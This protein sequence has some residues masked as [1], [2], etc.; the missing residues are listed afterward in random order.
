MKENKSNIVIITLFIT[1]LILT[2]FL[3]IK[4]NIN[5]FKEGIDSLIR[6]EN[7]NTLTISEKTKE[8]N[9]TIDTIFSNKIAGKY[10][11]IDI[12]GLFQNTMNKK[13]IEDV[14]DNKRV[15]KLSNNSLAFIYPD[16]D[17]SNWSDK[18]T[19]VSD[20]AKENNIYMLYV[21]APWRIGKNVT[22]PFYIKDNVAKVDKKF[23]TKLKE[24]KVNVLRLKDKLKG[25]EKDWFFGTDH[26]WNIETAFESYKIIMK[27]IDKNVNLGLKEEYLNNYKT[28]VYKNVFLG[29]Y[30]KRVGKYYGKPD[31]FAYILPN[32][33]TKFDVINNIKWDSEQSHLVGSFDKVFTYPEYVEKKELDRESSTYYTYA[34]G[35]KAEVKITNLKAYNDKKV[36]ILKDSF[37]EPVYPFIS[38]N[39]KET[40]IVDTRVFR[41]I[42][43]Y[44]Y[45]EKYKPD[46][47]LFIHTPTSLYDERLVD[48]QLR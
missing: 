23:V 21:D 31:D 48:F 26:H 28:T 18:I 37:A 14:E 33:E 30:G 3:T 1:Y 34:E 44:T 38:I 9:N 2:G 46:V 39:F 20:Y 40:R 7:W 35:G 13:V 12:Y 10:D 47:I 42:R 16:M 25:N 22:T 36:L 8:V 45:I 27:K 6:R 19:A 11:Y 4:N 41:R 29:T 15:I 5:T 32:F 24:N 43:L 17:I